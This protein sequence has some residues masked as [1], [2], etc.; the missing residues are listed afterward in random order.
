MLAHKA[1]KKR[2]APVGSSS[3]AP[4]RY[5]LVQT[6]NQQASTRPPQQGR[7]VARPPQQTAAV[8]TPFPNTAAEASNATSSTPQQLPL[9]QLW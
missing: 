7:W 6:G 4:Q 3:N 9:L 2:K 8:G 5:K 1:D